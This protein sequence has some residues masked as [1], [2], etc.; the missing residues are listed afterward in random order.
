MLDSSATDKL[1]SR[2]FAADPV[3]LRLAELCRAAILNGDFGDGERFPSERELAQRYD[4]SRATA[5]K[6]LSTL[7]AEGLLELRKGIGAFVRPQST[8]FASLRGMESFTAHVQE[9]GM[10][11]GTE[12]R[13][14]EHLIS[15]AAPPAVQAGLGLD[16]KSAE[17]L[18]Y[19]ERLRLADGEPMIL[20]QRWIRDSLAPGLKRADVEA[21]FYRVLETS[22]GLRMTGESHSISAVLLDDESAELF[23]QTP[24]AAALRVEGV[25]YVRDREPLW[26]QRLL[27]RGDRYQLHNETRGPADSAVTLSLTDTRLSA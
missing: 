20:E 19:L 15:S 16:Q 14:F 18:V 24:P 5:N 9:Q 25:G 11:P 7:V 3:H 22:F 17:P 23:G 6:A 26:R 21:S 13:K 10:T 12:V 27:Y 4:V 1:P 2:S 8:L